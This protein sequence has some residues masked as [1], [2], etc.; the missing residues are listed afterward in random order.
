MTE[1]SY[2]KSFLSM[3]AQ[4]PIRLAPDYVQ[5]PRQLPARNPYTLPHTHP[6]KKKRP[7]TD[8]AGDASVTIT[9]KPLRPTPGST[10]LTLPSVALSTTVTTLKHKYAA[11]MNADPARVKLLLK[12]KPLSDVKTLSELG[13]ADGDEVTITTMLMPGKAGDAAPPPPSAAAPEVEMND[14]K[15]RVLAGEGFWKELGVFLQER[16]GKEEVVEDPEKV[17]AVFR[18]AWKE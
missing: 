2:S 7:R 3:L 5:D 12:S 13:F 10:P 18:A 16:L 17:L 6:E 1:L 15:T 9:L 4:R 8:T 14:V 11:S